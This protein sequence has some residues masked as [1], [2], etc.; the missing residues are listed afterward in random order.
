MSSNKVCSICL[1]PYDLIEGFH[2]NKN[3]PDGRD[4]RCKICV[5]DYKKIHNKKPE[6]KDKRKSY[7]N[8]TKNNNSSK[9]SK[10]LGKRIVLRFDNALLGMIDNYK[11]LNEIKKYSEAIRQIFNRSLEEK[12][13]LDY[14][15]ALKSADLIH[16]HFLETTKITAL[17]N[18]YYSHYEKGKLSNFENDRELFF[19]VRDKLLSPL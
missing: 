2:K 7:L 6:T 11:S 13:Y 10:T 15:A 19:S 14:I 3:K 12:L 18:Q 9:V 4:I 8:K 1:K 17:L 5:S 16:V